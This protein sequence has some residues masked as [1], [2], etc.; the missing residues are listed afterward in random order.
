[1]SHNQGQMSFTGFG[2]MHFVTHP[3]GA[4][5]LAVMSLLVVGS[6]N[7]EGRGRNIVRRTPTN[8]LVDPL[9]ILDPHLAQNF[10][11]R[12]MAEPLRGCWIKK[13]S[14]QGHSIFS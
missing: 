5:L 1:M 10:D 13:G 9:I 14:K 7:V 4:P 3:F 2:Q 11:S 12:N 8:A 6:P